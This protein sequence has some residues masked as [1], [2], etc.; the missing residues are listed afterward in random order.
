MLVTAFSGCGD[1]L[2]KLC[3]G[4]KAWERI[5]CCWKASEWATAWIP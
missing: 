5:L 2:V 3:K 1:A 4:A